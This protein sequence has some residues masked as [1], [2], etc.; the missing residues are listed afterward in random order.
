MPRKMISKNSHLID[1]WKLFLPVAGSGRERER[2]GVDLVLG[3]PII[4]GPGS[5][6]TQ[7]YLVAGP[8]RSKVEAQSVE[9]YLR[10]RLARFLVSLRKPAQHAF[11]GMYRL[12]PVQR[13]DRTW[14]DTDLYKKYRITKD[15]IAFINSISVRW[16]RVMSKTI[17]EILAP[18]PEARPRI[19]AYS[20]DDKAHTGLLKVGQTM[21]DV[22]QRLAEQLKTAAIKNYRLELDEPAERDDG[23]IFSDHDV[24]AAL[25]RKRFENP[26]LEWMRCTVKDVKT[27]LTELR[28]GKRFTGTHHETFA[29]R[30]EQRAAVEK[31][32]AYFHSIWKEDMHAVPRFLWNAKMRFGKTFTAYQLAKKLGAKRVLVVTFK[33][34]VEDAWQTDLENHVDFD[35]W[36]YLSL[37]FGSDPTKVTA[38]S[39]SFIS[40]PSRICWAATTRG[41]SSPGTNGCTR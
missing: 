30:A 5:V 18:K 17:E 19:Y 31:T 9:S 33:P 26:E 28:R 23:G 35:G 8:L 32:H 12:V 11:S 27:V 3:P 1:V 25:V 24:R 21:R 2:S 4:G 37:H 29:M 39:R 40:A 10:T 13:W 36:Q 38:R 22:K 6:C 7:T 16:A 34:A 20:I 41:T 14:T 15:E